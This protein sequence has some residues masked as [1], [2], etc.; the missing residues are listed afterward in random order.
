LEID[1][2]IGKNHQGAIVTI[3]DR[4]TGMVKMVKVE[5]KDARLVASQTMKA[6]E[7]W[8]PYLKTITSDNGKEFALHQLISE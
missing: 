5:S 4:V 3:N 2:I 8:K 7:R 6:L 1:T